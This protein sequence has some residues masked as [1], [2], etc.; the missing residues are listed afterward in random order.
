M[1]MEEQHAFPSFFAVLDDTRSIYYIF[2]ADTNKSGSYQKVYSIY[3]PYKYLFIK[4]LSLTYQCED[5]VYKNYIDY[6][7]R[8]KKVVFW[9]VGIQ[10]LCHRF[11]SWLFYI[12]VFD[13]LDRDILLSKAI[14]Y[15]LE[16]V[17][18]SYILYKNMHIQKRNKYIPLLNTPPKEEQTCL[19]IPRHVMEALV[20]VSKLDESIC[21]ITCELIKDVKQIGVTP[22]YHLFDAKCLNAWIKNKKS[23]PD[24]RKEVVSY[25]LYEQ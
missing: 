11:R 10:L 20:R 4:S 8:Y 5:K 15:P 22:C 18:Q 7:R 3:L 13:F 17:G 12:P 14:S 2:S 16:D 25:A 23:C 6:D 19:Q 21:T 9:P 24:C 1:Y